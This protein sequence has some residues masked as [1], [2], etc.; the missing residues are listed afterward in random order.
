MKLPYSERDVNSFDGK[1]Q[2]DALANSEHSTF[3]PLPNAHCKGQNLD[4]EVDNN[5]RI[6]DS[7]L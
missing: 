1:K 2:N 3:I 4:K 7:V 5:F 6:Q